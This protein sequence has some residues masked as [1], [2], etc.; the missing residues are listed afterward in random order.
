MDKIPQKRIDEL[1]AMKALLEDTVE[2]YCDE[3]MVSGECA[4]TMVAS[5]ADAKLNVEFPSYE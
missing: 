3:H 2:Y 5:L 1:M 4:W